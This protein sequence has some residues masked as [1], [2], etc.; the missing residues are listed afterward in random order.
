[1]IEAVEFACRQ[2]SAYAKNAGIYYCSAPGNNGWEIATA[3]GTVGATAAA[4]TF[5]I[6]EIVR[7]RRERER[8]R[9]ESE[10]Q[11]LNNQFQ[12]VSGIMLEMV[13]KFPLNTDSHSN[14]F[15]AQV[16]IYESLLAAS[17]RTPPKLKTL[18]GPLFTKFGKI[19]LYNNVKNCRTTKARHDLNERMRIDSQILP[20]VILQL[21]SARLETALSSWHLT[22]SGADAA[23][24][25]LEELHDEM[26]EHQKHIERYR[27]ELED[28]N[29]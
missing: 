28:F 26:L 15:H 3:F 7:S 1:M 4:A 8:I 10:R 25:E 18:I 11:I 27:Q 29:P 9:I 23:I 2:S 19:A 21:M 12:K 5:G 24:A 14:R 17:T 22:G 6:V 20:G 16:S 13:E